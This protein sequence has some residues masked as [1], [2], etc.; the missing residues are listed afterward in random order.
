MKLASDFRE[1]AR[2]ALKGKW[3]LAVITG[4][5][6]SILGA[7][8]HG[9]GFSFNFSGFNNS[10]VE[11]EVQ[12]PPIGGAESFKEIYSGIDPAF[13]AI[14]GT[15]FAVA[16]AIGL[17]VGIAFFIL[18]SIVTPGYAKFNLN[19]V[20][21]ENADVGDLFKYFKYWKN[22]V[23]ANLL[24]SVYIFLWSLLCFIP[25]IIATYTYAMVPYIMAENPELTAREACEKSKEMMDGNRL[26]LFCLT[27]SFIG[28]SLLCVLTCGIGNIVLTP[29]IEASVADFYREISDTRPIPEPDESIPVYIPES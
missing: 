26:R 5:I 28:W 27:F 25:G 6:A 13:W 16:L 1:S 29:Y 4:I 24:R 17:V 8:T 9:G 2:E 11:T 20:D 3:G 7:S 15:V 18:G 19:L 23:L 12:I 21:G 10:E 14:M 22:V